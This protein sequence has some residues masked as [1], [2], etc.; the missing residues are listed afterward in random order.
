MNWRA[1]RAS[2]V[3][4]AIVEQW[5]Q[6]PRV[7]G[8][9]VDE[10]RNLRYL[11]IEHP[12]REIE[13]VGERYLDGGPN[14]TPEVRGDKKNFDLI[15]LAIG[16][17]EERAV[18]TLTTSQRSPV[19]ARM[20]TSYW[21]NETYGQPDLSGQRRYLVSGTGDGGLID[22]LRLR[23]ADFREDRIGFE[24]TREGS[25]GFEEVRNLREECY[26]DPTTD[27]GAELFNRARELGREHGFVEK[28]TRRLR[29]DTIA[30]IQIKSGARVSDAFHGKSSFVN[31]FLVSLLFEAGGF[32]PRFGKL[33][34]TDTD[35]FDEVIIRHGTKSTDHLKA[36]FTQDVSP[37]I[38]A[39]EKNRAGKPIIEQ[40]QERGFWETGWPFDRKPGP[41]SAKRDYVPDATIAVS[42]GFVSALTS[43]FGARGGKYRATLHR[44]VA[45]D[46]AQS[47]VHLQQMAHYHGPRGDKGADTSTGRLFRIND[48]VIGLAAKT[49]KVLV[50]PDSGHNHDEHRQ[51]L[52]DDMQRLGGE[53]WDP[54]RMD[55][56]V[57]SLFACP[58]IYQPSGS[59]DPTTEG[60][61]VA[62]LFADSTEVGAFDESCVAQIVASCEEFG[63]YLARVEV[64]EVREVINVKAQA[65]FYRTAIPDPKTA[66]LNDLKIL[67]ASTA[68]PPKV[69]VGFINL[70]WWT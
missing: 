69:P 3:A 4:T 28:I 61:V 23:I 26:E 56:E 5:E 12:T 2:D 19:V 32:T 24:L 17:G 29:A 22:L 33:E 37:L 14:R 20:N 13:W 7:E 8:V 70:E 11:K 53:A 15:I 68:S 44:V 46:V 67:K 60:G 54:K 21:R 30:S 57:S 1:G 25:S 40:S 16:F 49:R 27:R 62:V 43:I 36:I 31:R 38:E 42:S 55:D 9:V 65:T 35:G 50:T 34:E 51:L 6:E 63:R 47:E 10:W 41:G 45:M 58:L 59:G 18:S 52:R 39:L 48:A 64:G 66:I